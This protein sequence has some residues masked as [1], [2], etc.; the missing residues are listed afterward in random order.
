MFYSS[1]FTFVFGPYALFLL[2][3][4]GLFALFG[5]IIHKLRSN[6]VSIPFISKAK[7]T[8]KVFLFI[9]LVPAV[10]A[11]LFLFMAPKKTNTFLWNLYWKF[12][13][14]L[15]TLD[16][17]GWIMGHEFCLILGLSFLTS[18][19]LLAAYL[20]KTNTSK[21]SI[22]VFICYLFI[23]IPL[24]CGLFYLMGHFNPILII[25]ILGLPGALIFFL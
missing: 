7:K 25:I 8:F 10:I 18:L 9:Y 24:I 15:R 5:Y 12:D 13:G 11:L 22:K 19:I 3:V 1:M 6:E 21:L 4:Y 23:S 20:Q 17:D 14:M 2:M 16:L